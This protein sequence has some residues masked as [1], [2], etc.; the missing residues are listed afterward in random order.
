MLGDL[1][2]LA[3]SACLLVSALDPGRLRVQ[4]RPRGEDCESADEA[5]PTISGIAVAR[6]P[7]QGLLAADLG[8]AAVLVLLGE[9]AGTTS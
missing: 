6:R 4:R 1:S 8:L 9:D 5:S 7:A 2:V 3:R